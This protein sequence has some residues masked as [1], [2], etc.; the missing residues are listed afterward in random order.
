MRSPWRTS[1]SLNEEAPTTS[2]TRSLVL[3]R[4][5]RVVEVL[6]EASVRVHPIRTKVAIDQSF[7]AGVN[8]TSVRKHLDCF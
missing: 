8:P 1:P 7:L 5:F 6:A 3:D 4:V 2:R